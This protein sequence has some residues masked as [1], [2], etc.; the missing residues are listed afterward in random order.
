MNELKSPD[1]V[2]RRFSALLNARDVDG[3]LA[4]Y[5]PDA[6]FVSEPGRWVTGR[7]RSERCSS[8]SP[9]WSPS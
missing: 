9:L 2:I 8:G 3:A 1:G 7:A 6:A 5:E 4:L